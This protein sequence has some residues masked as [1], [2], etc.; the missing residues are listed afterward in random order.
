MVDERKDKDPVVPVQHFRTS[1]RKIVLQAIIGAVILASGIGIGA[2][3]T[4]LFMRDKVIWRFRGPMRGERK[5]PIEDWKS[6][7]NLT[8]EQ[9]KQA[10]KVFTEQMNKMRT[11][12]DNLEKQ[13]EQ[14]RAKFVAAIKTIF[15][16]EQ[17]EK[18]QHDFKQREEHFQKRRSQRGEKEQRDRKGP[19]SQGPGP[20]SSGPIREAPRTPETPRHEGPRPDDPGL[21]RPMGPAPPHD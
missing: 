10:Q 2:G 13:F 8:D 17:F 11:G 16:P 5:S 12:Q 20:R 9:A 1:R 15:T 21:A 3:G 19:R 6:R 4:F 7:Y 18:W 14:E